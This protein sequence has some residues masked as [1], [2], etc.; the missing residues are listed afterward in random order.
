MDNF[1]VLAFDPGGATG[2]ATACY[3][4]ESHPWWIESGT[5][6]EPEHHH[7]IEDKILTDCLGYLSNDNQVQPLTV[8]TESFEFRQNPDSANQRRGLELVSREYIGVMK[9]ACRKV[10]VPIVQQMPAHALHFMTD[11]KLKKMGHLKTPLHDCRHQNDALRHLFFYLIST[12]HVKE[13]RDKLK[14]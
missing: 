11:E 8:V 1:Q 7:I 5:F 2:W 12:L 10:S 3:N 13:W 14:S 9:L 6:W 4:G